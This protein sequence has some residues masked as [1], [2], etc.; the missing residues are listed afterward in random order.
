MERIANKISIVGMGMVGSSIAYAMTLLGLAAELVLVDEDGEKA[1]GEA[2]DLADSAAFGQKIKVR[3]GEF[4]DISGSDL[5]IFSAGVNRNVGENQSDLLHR[6]LLILEK[7][8]AG[9]GNGYGETILLMVS[10]PVDVMTYAAMK[11][12][13]LPQE[14]VLGLG[15]VLE[16]SRFRHIL[17]EQFKIG[18]GNI[19]AYVAGEHGAFAVPL[20]S[21]VNIAGVSLDQFCRLRNIT[22]FDRKE[23][24]DRT[25]TGAYEIVFHKGVSNYAL[26]RAAVR[27]CQGILRDD[28]TILTVTGNMG[29]LHG[30]EEVCLSYPCRI[31][32]KGRRE[33]L[34]LNP[35]QEE[36]KALKRAADSVRSLQK[37]ISFH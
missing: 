8:L 32:R 23:L 4:K 9:L 35:S 2:L 26:S 33:I 1:L 37:E 30:L 17:G 24:F 3:S 27:I 13:G 7:C 36:L 25:L 28:N 29:G 10:N 21:A 14:R 16:T 18:V 11:M 12:S 34:P 5:V 15:T 31:N 6:N 22:D 20:W 19:N